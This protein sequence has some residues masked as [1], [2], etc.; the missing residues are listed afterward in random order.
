MSGCTHGAVPDVPVGELAVE[1]N[2]EVP[3]TWNVFEG[4][5]VPMPTKPSVVWDPLSAQVWTRSP[6]N[7]KTYNS[8]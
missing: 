8:I 5:A 7:Y 2:L 1:T 3:T 6:G 4:D